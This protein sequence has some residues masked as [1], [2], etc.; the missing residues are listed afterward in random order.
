MLRS[1]KVLLLLPLLAGLS[2][3][4]QTNELGLW[5]GLSADY[6]LSKR[7]ALQLN[8][9]VRFSDNLQVTRAYLG[10]AGLSYKLT[11]H[12]KVAGYY[13]YTGRL[14]KNKETDLYYYRPYHRFYGEA[15]YETK[16]GG[17]LELDYRLRYQHQFRDDAEGV[18]ATG[19]YLRNKVGLSYNN[20]TRLTPFASVDLF[21]RVATPEQAGGF[22]QLRY[23]AGTRIRL[24]DA[25]SLD[26]FLQKDAGLNGSD[27]GSGLVLGATYKLK[28]GRTKKKAAR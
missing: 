24:A 21:Y 3:R 28:M 5:T 2:A 20:P 12:W 11:K 17:G 22:D 18:V 15:S 10:E 6:R 4:A 8:S 23:R 14:K 16:L 13:R 26:L 19:S 7:F 25:H 9:Q 1:A 27:E